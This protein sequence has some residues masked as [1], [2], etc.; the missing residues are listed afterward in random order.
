M[1]IETIAARVRE[2]LHYDPSTGAF[3]RRVRTAQ[4]HQVGDRADFIVTG[5]GLKGYCRISFDSTRYLAHRLAWLYVH[6]RWPEF[7]ID[8]VNGIKNDNRIANLRDIPNALNRQ[9]IRGPRADN[10]ISGILGVTR[11]KKKWRSRIQINS[12]TVNLGCFDSAQD[13]KNAYLKAKR[14]LHAGCTI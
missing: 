5:G 8:H 1:E 13:A 9:N 6:G 7:D 11:H 2:L 4:R 12:R 14:L 10:A 3:T